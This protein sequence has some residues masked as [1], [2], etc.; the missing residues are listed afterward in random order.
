[1]VSIKNPDGV[2]TDLSL[3]HGGKTDAGVLPKTILGHPNFLD[4]KLSGLRRREEVKLAKRLPY[5]NKSLFNKSCLARDST[6]YF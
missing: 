1:V 2:P 3:R 5:A 6:D 4:A